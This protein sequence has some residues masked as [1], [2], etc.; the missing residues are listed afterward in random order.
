MNL[1]HMGVTLVVRMSKEAAFRLQYAI[2]DFA[3]DRANGT[4][5]LRMIAA[6]QALQASMDAHPAGK[7]R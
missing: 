7:S 6:K 5:W 3:N 1:N 4:A 2:S